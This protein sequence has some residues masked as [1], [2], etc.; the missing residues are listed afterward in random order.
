MQK[1]KKLNG[2]CKLRTVLISGS[3]GFLGSYLTKCLKKNYK[4]IILKR[5]FSKTWRIDDIISEV[6]SYDIDQVDIRQ[7]FEDNT[8]DIVIHTATNYG[9]SNE[10]L[11][12]IIE[13][14]F[15]FPLQLLEKS[16]FNRTKM[17][18][19]ADTAIPRGMNPYA[20]SKKQFLDWLK[21]YQNR[22]H[23]INMKI[24]H[25]Y[26][27]RSDSNNFITYLIRNM[28]KN[29]SIDLTEGYQQRDF[30]FVEDVVN[31]FEKVL[32]SSKINKAYNEFEVG[33][34]KSISIRN[35]VQLICKVIDSKSVLNFG[36]TP[37][38]RGEVMESKSNIV[39]LKKIGWRPKITLEEGILRTVEYE[40]Q[41]SD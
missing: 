24:E 1:E 25:M 2:S 41:K 32:E 13:S 30:I 19:N 6:L 33:S 17:F 37:Y 7:V 14:N 20:L 23:I 16:V 31:A 40:R 11:I 9:R 12:D 3:T 38:R 29:K 15:L 27:C 39:K 21:L 26:G 18:I 36:A 22:I 8:I 4:V 28:L 34:G 10:E 5:S 35:I